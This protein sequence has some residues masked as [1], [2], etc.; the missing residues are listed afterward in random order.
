VL[1]LQHAVLFRIT[2]NGS[3]N[4][5]LARVARIC[6]RIGYAKRV[7]WTWRPSLSRDFMNSQYMDNILHAPDAAGLTHKIVLFACGFQLRQARHNRRDLVVIGAMVWV[8][9]NRFHVLIW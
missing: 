2:T 9:V 1:S 8:C 7:F 4:S 5:L 3:K 6:A